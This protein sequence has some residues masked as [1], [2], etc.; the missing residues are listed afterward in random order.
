MGKIV[1]VASYPKSGNTWVRLMLANYLAPGDGPLPLDQIG[2]Y[3]TGDARAAYFETVAPDQPAEMMPPHVFA[4]LRPQVHRYLSE[5]NPGRALVKTHTVNAAANGVPQVN[6]DVTD[7]AIYIARNPMDVAVSFSH[8]MGLSLDE[9]IAFMGTPNACTGTG[10]RTI[11]AFQGSWSEHIRSWLE[12]NAFPVLVV[13]YENLVADPRRS[14]LRICKFL[15]LPPD[16]RRVEKALQY[17]Q[18]DAVASQEAQE[19]FIEKP[20]TAERF[21][22]EGRAGGGAA[23]LTDGQKAQIAANHGAVMGGLGYLKVERVDQARRTWHRDEA[24]R[25]RRRPAPLEPPSG[26]STGPSE[27]SRIDGAGPKASGGGKEAVKGKRPK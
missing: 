19:G 23:V 13:T 20:P 11:G 4:R 24:M 1:W 22:R 14:F 27:V 16:G 3:V 2:K 18:F 7:R 26:R 10:G 17:S 9:T 15:G 21:F 25:N 12:S 5:I 6:L 8:H